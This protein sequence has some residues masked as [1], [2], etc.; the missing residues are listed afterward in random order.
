MNDQSAN[1]NMMYIG[2]NKYPPIIKKIFLM[3]AILANFYLIAGYGLLNLLA[4]HITYPRDFM[5]ALMFRIHKFFFCQQR[6][7]LK[8]L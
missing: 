2:I 5:R 7:T 1:R 3:L 8:Y 4:G 6:E